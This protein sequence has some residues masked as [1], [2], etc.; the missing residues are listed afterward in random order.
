MSGFAFRNAVWDNV[1]PGAINSTIHWVDVFQSA[2]DKLG[3]SIEATIAH[4][5]Q[6]GYE[7][8]K[9]QSWDRIKESI[10]SGNPCI[11]WESYEFALVKG[12]DDNKLL[13]NGVVG[14]SSISREQFC[15][16]DFPSLFVLI[17]DDRFDFSEIDAFKMSCR[18]AVTIGFVDNPPYISHLH[19][20]LGVSAYKKWIDE[21]GGDF[22]AFGNAYHTQYLLEARKYASLY[23][24][25]LA[26]RFSGVP[27]NLLLRS[28][29]RFAQSHNKLMQFSEYFPYSPASGSRVSYNAESIEHG[30]KLLEDCHVMEIEGF[31]LIATAVEHFDATC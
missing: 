12:Y 28:S 23:L 3:F 17:V 24:A 27:Q 20:V 18:N 22:N 7:S 31:S 26:A 13:I 30:K 19:P 6:L 5:G 9:Q 29:E 16:G 1:L 15:E 2:F 21:L 10:D 4:K 11:I 14:D 8:Y 25:K